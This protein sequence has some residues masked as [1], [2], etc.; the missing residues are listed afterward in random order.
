MLFKDY[1]M[2]WLR[3]FKSMKSYNTQR[4]YKNII[5]NHLIP[6]I[7]NKEMYDISIKDLQE[8]INKRL[9]NPATCKHIA[10]TL[11][12]IFK[13]AKEEKIIDKTIY[14]FLQTPYYE[15]NEKRSLTED[16]KMCIR[17]I[18]CDNMGK[19]FVHIL[20][21]CGL[22]KG[23][24]LALTKNDIVDNEIIINKSI[25]FINGKPIVGETK[26]H[27]SIR[28]VPIPDF[29]LKELLSYCKDIDNKLFY[30]LNGEYL[31][32]SEY[33]KMWKNIVKSIDN[34]IGVET[35]LTAHIFRHNYATI[36][37]YSDISLKQAAKLM[38]HSNVNM[39][40]N[41]Y[42]HLDAKNEKVSEKINQI[43]QI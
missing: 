41:V 40:L 26:T 7:G 24:T 39:I 28:K 29:L 35:K 3:V 5:E 30:N 42:A 6:E 31:N 10:L 27:S 2:E 36:L 32:D 34:E 37:Y 15:S 16:E 43:F 8:I 11:K 33:V 23:E 9:S 13:V 1:S 20:Y 38:G 14:T 21:C 17:N 25:H 4:L 19:I 12:Q 22:R 18:K